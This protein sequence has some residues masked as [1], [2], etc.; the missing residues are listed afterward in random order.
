MTSGKRPTDNNGL[1]YDGGMKM[2]TWIEEAIL[3]CLEGLN[4]S[5]GDVHYTYKE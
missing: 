3:R 2:Q 1:N 4:E 5:L